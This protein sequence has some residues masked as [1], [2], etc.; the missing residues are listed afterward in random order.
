MPITDLLAKRAKLGFHAPSDDLAGKSIPQSPFQT[1]SAF[2]TE[3]LWIHSENR[4]DAAQD[5]SDKTIRLS[6]LHENLAVAIKDVKVWN[7]FFEIGCDDLS[8]S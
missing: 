3:C 6:P 8:N 4:C 5:K 2:I 1:P 7:S